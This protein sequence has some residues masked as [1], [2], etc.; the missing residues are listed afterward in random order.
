MNQIHVE[1]ESFVIFEHRRG[2]NVHT[3]FMN[4][5][6]FYETVTGTE[7]ESERQ[8]ARNGASENFSWSEREK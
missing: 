1:H 5:P 2:N 4:K 7:S 6:I 8:Q 3:A